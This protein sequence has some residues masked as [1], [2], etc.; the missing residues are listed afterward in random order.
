MASSL[1]W[2]GDNEVV[3]S[4]GESVAAATPGAGTSRV[5]RQNVRSGATITLLRSPNNS[6][7]LDIVAPGRIAFDVFSNRQNLQEISLR[8]KSTQSSSRWLTQGNSQDRQPVYSPDGEWVLFTSNRSGSLDLWE[9]ST[10]TNAL[11]RLTDNP[12]D[13]WDPAFT[14]D[15]KN[16]LWSSNRSGHLE[17]WM[18]NADGSGAR[19]VTDDGADA[20]N[21]TMT[22]DGSWIVY[23]SGNPTKLGIWKIHSDGS[24]ATRLVSA[25]SYTPEVSPDGQYALYSP[26]YP[27]NLWQWSESP[28][29]NPS[30]SKSTSVFL[31]RGFLEGTVDAEWEGDRF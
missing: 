12:A 3:Y 31:S 13:D 19:Q 10:K 11:R 26:H 28:T 30:P 17:I 20:E 27:R 6:L 29:V 15:G 18:A 9:I 14:P 1:A 25:R 23:T 4:Q 24:G 16:I 5:I 8:Q 7:G 22:R 2:S 21:P